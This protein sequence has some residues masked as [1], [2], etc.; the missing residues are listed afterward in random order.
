MALSID[1]SIFYHV[2]S[3]V[4]CQSVRKLVRKGVLTGVFL[5]K[6]NSALVSSL[7]QE[8]WSCLSI[9]QAPMCDIGMKRQRLI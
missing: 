5:Q 4:W 9:S 1:A 6:L 7:P 2:L 3:S 8:P